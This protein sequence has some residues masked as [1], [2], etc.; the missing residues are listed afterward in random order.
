MQITKFGAGALA[1]ACLV[2]PVQAADAIG[3]WL[4]EDRDGVVQIGDCGTLRKVAPTGS[5]CGVVVW[6]RDAVDAA[7]GRPPVDKKNADPAL[8]GRP[9]MGLQVIS[10]MR[11]SKAS[12]RWDGR[13]YNIDDGKTYTGTLTLK[14]EGQ[15]RVE[16]CVAIVCSGE[17]WTRQ[18]P[19]QRSAPVNR[20][21]AD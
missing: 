16:G 1:L 17:T 7:T 18:A 9:I 13:I 21:R 15:L 14:S 4:N 19:P 2:A 6:I 8:R 11:P 5:L 3:T 12:N 20:G 10:Q